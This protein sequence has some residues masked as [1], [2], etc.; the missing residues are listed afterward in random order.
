MSYLDKAQDKILLLLSTF[1]RNPSWG[2]GSR[3]KSTCARPGSWPRGSMPPPARILEHHKFITL[4]RDA[5]AYDDFGP[6]RHGG[7]GSPAEGQR[8]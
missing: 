2:I 4:Q 5:T 3:R 8:K 6:H 7:R 1:A